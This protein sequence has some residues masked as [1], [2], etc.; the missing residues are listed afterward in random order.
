M[1]VD[2]NVD[3][4][5]LGPRLRPRLVADAGVRSVQVELVR[6]DLQPVARVAGEQD[7]DVA[8]WSWRSAGRRR[9]H[10]LVHQLAGGPWRLHVPHPTVSRS[11]GPGGR[12]VGRY[13]QSGRTLSA[14]SLQVE[15][16]GGPQPDQRHRAGWRPPSGP[17]SGPPSDTPHDATAP[18]ISSP[19][20]Q[21]PSYAGK[22]GEAAVEGGAQVRFPSS[23]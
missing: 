19:T 16:P 11:P 7:A 22:G 9:G 10:L 4:R 5:W 21:A 6:T 1:A 12:S 2:Q 20:E 14:S 13:P 17:P 3:Q 18:H 23:A 15:S 8:I